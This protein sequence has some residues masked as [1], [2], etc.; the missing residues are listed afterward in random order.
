MFVKKNEVG[1]GGMCFPCIY[2]REEIRK[3]IEKE[4]IEQRPYIKCDDCSYKSQEKRD[5][6]KTKNGELL[7]KDCTVKK[8]ICIICGCKMNSYEDVPFFMSKY[9]RCIACACEGYKMMR[10]RY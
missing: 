2:R 6:V 10:R 7:C 3:K 9:K 5:F 1:K 4:K 8:N